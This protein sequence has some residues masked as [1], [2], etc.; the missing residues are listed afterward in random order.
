MT[1]V[2]ALVTPYARISGGLIAML[3]RIG[4]IALVTALVPCALVLGAAFGVFMFAVVMEV[5]KIVGV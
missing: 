3:K 1:S 5:I 2:P 4:F